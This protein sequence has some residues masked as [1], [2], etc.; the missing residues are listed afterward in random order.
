MLSQEHST[1][2]S[3]KPIRNTRLCRITVQ[4]FSVCAA[5]LE[6]LRKNVYNI[7][8][9]KKGGERM[10]IPEKTAKILA[11]LENSGYE[12]YLVGGCVRDTLMN[13]PIHDFDIT[14][15]ALP[16]E[17]LEVFGGY[18]VIPT[19]LK[20]GTVT[21]ICEGE[22]FEITTFRVDGDYSDSRRPDSVRFTASIEEDLARRDFTMNAIAMRSD[23]K[24]IDP[25]CGKSD[26][27]NRI[28][29][30]VG[31]P[32]KRF[33]EDALR[34]M[35]AL[36]F[37]SRLGFEIENE[38]ACAVHKLCGRLDFIAGERIREELDGILCGA[39]CAEIML[40]FSDVMVQIIPELKLCIGFEQYS[41]Y[42]KYTVWEHIAR[43]VAGSPEND[44]TVRR[45]MLFHDIG[46]PDCFTRDDNG[47]G[48]FKGH[49]EISAQIAEKVMQ[50]LRYDSKSISDVCTLIRRHSDKIQ[51]E[52]Q[53]KR[54]ISKIGEKLFFSLINV[55]KADN[56]AKREFVLEELSQFEYFEECAR[57][58]ISDGEC[59]KLS[60]LAVN[61][62]DML[63]MGL[64]G[65][66]VGEA[67][68]KLLSLVIDGELPNERD[69][70]ISFLE[71]GNGG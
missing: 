17:I 35:R 64:Q 38:T 69:A 62:K 19:G 23:G 9:V 10:I 44:L 7:N 39:F 70:L 2:I 12:A 36:R 31:A 56:S 3:D 33:S 65:K 47:V 28:I 60:Q 43:S 48:H 57:R 32:V 11:E 51:T 20:H 66:A 55:K 6:N 4:P 25:F 63:T 58:I 71:G 21:V 5:G 52:K 50:K 14:T 26:I 30:C 46:K 68:D 49:A 41:P 8:T 24:L 34:I 13:Q 54:L 42:H 29:R 18:R 45:T 15:N 59:M 1:R 37:A 22:P 16:D 40:E 53:I 27:E 61:G 67:L